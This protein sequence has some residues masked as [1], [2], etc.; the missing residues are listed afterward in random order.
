[1]L[2]TIDIENKNTNFGI[3]EDEKLVTNF[4]IMTDKNRSTE[5][6]KLTIKLILKDKKIDLS[7]ISDIILSTVVPELNSSYEIIAR[8]II[9]KSPIVI[10]AGVKTG[11]NIKCE[12]PREVG[13]DRIIRAV[14]ATGRFK[15]NIIIISASSVTT[16]DYINDKKEFLG[17]LI[18]PGISLLQD[19]LVRGSGK[20]PRVEI[21]KP[22]DIIG[23][24]TEKAI[25]RGI[26]FGYNKAVF[27]IVD[28]IVK[29]HSLKKE[30]TKILVTG[31]KAHLLANEI[32]TF[33]EDQV[34]GI[35]GLKI[36]YD[37]N[38]NKASWL[39]PY[40][41]YFSK[42]SIF[43]LWNFTSKSLKSTIFSIV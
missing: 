8:E 34:L 10:S 15:E 20:L 38:K 11:L 1:M 27:G 9:G 7:D 33:E 4:S 22:E 3:F 43:T 26:Y 37:L 24:N 23:K 39:E 30:N 25:Q 17:G 31:L 18:L 40:F 13:T 19:S 5:E 36:I 42:S 16:I 41:L 32:Y 29:F 28:E 14:A 2:L 6:I 21:K 35:K 12:S